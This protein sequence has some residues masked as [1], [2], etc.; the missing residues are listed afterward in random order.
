LF[1]EDAS[2]RARLEKE[3]S[4]LPSALISSA[5]AG[6]AV[7]LGTSYF[8]PLSGF[9]TKAD[10]LAIGRSMQTTSGLFWPTPVLNL[11]HE[12]GALR[13]GQRI[14]LRDPN[15][16]GNP[17]LAIQ[18]VEDIGIFSP[19]EMEELTVLVYGM[20]DRAHHGVAEFL[21]VGI[22]GIFSPVQ[23][24]I[25]SCCKMTFPETFPM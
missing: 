3:A 15:V 25:N 17:V 9:M 22:A 13:P 1:V 5:A 10:A 20:T 4:S 14:A 2:E 6:N 12:A 24:L 18:R 19:T 23:G 7:M 8:T 21:S 11:V 16:E